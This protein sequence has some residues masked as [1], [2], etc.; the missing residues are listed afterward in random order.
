M[1]RDHAG[2]AAVYL[3]GKSGV[4]G[5][6]VK[7]NVWTVGTKCKVVDIWLPYRK[8]RSSFSIGRMIPE[9]TVSTTEAG[10]TDASERHPSGAG[11]G[12]KLVNGS[13]YS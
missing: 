6:G 3:C 9:S 1:K 12:E 7:E 5:F 4:I 8:L 2:G 11:E 10:R 13:R